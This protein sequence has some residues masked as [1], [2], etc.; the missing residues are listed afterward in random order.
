MKN[1]VR[2]SCIALTFTL[3]VEVSPS[4]AQ[5]QPPPIVADPQTTTPLKPGD[6]LRL[7]VAGFPDLSGEQVILS[8]G[9]IQLPMAGSLKVSRLSPVQATDLITQA[10]Q[11]YVR[12]PQVAL[13]LLSFSPLR[14][15]ITGEV[16]QPGPRL[17]NPFIQQAQ[18]NRDAGS[19]PQS[20]SPITASDVLILAG[21]I[22]PDADLRNITIRRLVPRNSLTVNSLGVNSLGVNS[23]GTSKAVVQLSGKNPAA[24]S[25]GTTAFPPQAGSEGSTVIPTGMVRTEIKVDLWK[26]IQSGDLSADARIYDEDEIIVPRA[27]FS[28]SDQQTL[29]TST[30]AP[31]KITIQV[32]GEVN[33]PGPVEVSPNSRVAETIAAAG[34]ITDKANKRAVELYRM[35][36]TGQLERQTFELE[37]PSVSLRNGDL[38]V[39]RKTGFS[40]FIDVVGRVFVP[41]YPITTILNL[42][43]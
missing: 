9:T 15:S 7:T 10:L 3:M 28:N 27:Q 23:L 25:S 42:F 34:G 26:A 32:T 18:Q 39:V 11:P 14:V 37:K 29:L 31:A 41:I 6:R 40:K 33:R 1:S 38:L 8:D 12:R 35:S 22:T 17:L 24:I 4:L 20:S 19:G 13:S 30:I 43:R 36:S 16:L 2:L 21:G 5:S